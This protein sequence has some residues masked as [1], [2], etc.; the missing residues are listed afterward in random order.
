MKHQFR[1]MYCV[2]DSDRSPIRHKDASKD[3]ETDK[4]WLFDSVEEAI[5]FRE[6]NDL[7]DVYDE[8][9]YWISESH[10]YSL[11]GKNP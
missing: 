5:A 10:A 2:P 1:L 11:T 9:F 6:A 4:T 3:S 7:L 8:A